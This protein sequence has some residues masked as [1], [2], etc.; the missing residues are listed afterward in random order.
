MVGLSAIKNFAFSG[1]LQDS[2]FFCIL[3]NHEL[4]ANLTDRVY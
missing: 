1:S 2:I 3:L 4:Q